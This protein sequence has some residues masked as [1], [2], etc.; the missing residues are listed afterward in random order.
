[1]KIGIVGANGFVGSALCRNFHKNNEVIKINKNNYEKEKMEAYDVLIN[2]AMPSAKYWANTNP[3]EDFKKTVELTADLA[4]NWKYK[5]IIQIS[6]ISVEKLDSSYSINKKA[7]EVILNFKNS[8]IVR[9]GTLY[10]IGLKK[11]VLFDL[12]NGNTVYANQKSEFDFIDIDFCT[13]WI[14]DNLDKKDTVS[15]GAKN[16]ISLREIVEKFQIKANFEGKTNNIFSKN[17]PEG[18]PNSNEVFTFIEN[19]IKQN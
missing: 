3:Y 1:M 12:L 8:L 14:L 19:Y 10:G 7:A 16:T 2:S 15:L 17:I 4:Y 11:G 5:K 6:T 18:M 9:L 13:K